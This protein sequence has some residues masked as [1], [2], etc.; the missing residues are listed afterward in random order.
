MSG[1]PWMIYGAYGFTGR[2]L[3]EEAVARGHRPVLAGRAQTRLVPLAERLGLDYRVFDLADAVK[4][5][6]ALAEVSLVL[7]TAGP[8]RHSCQLLVQGCLQS[9]THYLDVGGELG[10]CRQ[11]LA[12]DRAARQRGIVL[13]PGAAFA[14]VA[15]DC[16][17]WYVTQQLEHPTHLEIATATS[18]T[19]TPSPGTARSAIEALSDG[20]FMRQQGELVRISLRGTMK[21]VRFKD[22]QRTVLPLSLADLATA[23]QSTAV[24]NIT[25]YVAFPPEQARNLTRSEPIL[26]RLYAFAPL[27]HLVQ[28]QLARTSPGPDPRA[29]QTGRSQ[30]WVSAR[31][32]AG[33]VKQAWLEAA[34]AYRFTAM[35]GVRCVERVLHQ[36]RPG[37]VTPAQVWG[38]DL[39]LEIPGSQRFDH[40]AQQPPQPAI[41][42]R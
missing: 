1:T 8:F 35:A 39:V 23:H 7:N 18:I 2:L 16:L 37:A 30:V 5:R 26:R 42:A 10:S 9:G 21:Q 15:S 25:T 13:L 14:V 27:R 36:P 3:A 17:A 20:I 41:E 11:V 24:P 33:T 32:Q 4:L 19:A 38:A 29:R 28:Q 12:H 40:L 31:N 34:E 6:A 22:R